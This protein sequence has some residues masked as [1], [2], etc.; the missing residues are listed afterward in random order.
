MLFCTSEAVNKE[1]MGTVQTMFERD[2]EERGPNVSTPFST[3]NPALEVLLFFYP[4]FLYINDTFII[5]KK[6][7][8]RVLPKIVTFVLRL[9]IH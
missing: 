9:L 2:L 4:C 5:Q 3:K 1:V 8:G 7:T 6:K